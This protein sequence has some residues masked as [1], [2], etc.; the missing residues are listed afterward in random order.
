MGAW[1]T[2]CSSELGRASH[3]RHTY[4][5]W[6]GG[7]HDVFCTASRD[8]TNGKI[9]LTQRG[10]RKTNSPIP[11]YHPGIIW[12]I[13]ILLIRWW[14]DHC[15]RIF[16][17]IKVWSCRVKWSSCNAHYYWRSTYQHDHCWMHLRLCW[18]IWTCFFWVDSS[19][20]G[21]PY[22]TH[23]SQQK[24]KKN[25]CMAIIYGDSATVWSEEDS[26]TQAQAGE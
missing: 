14:H 9:R 1:R 17:I 20:E 24:L 5:P 23:K 7:L 2:V 13:S 16:S 8:C 25:K 4:W 10:D 26:E 18:V 22:C 3:S 6:R 12:D 15:F 19:L 21:N 11:W